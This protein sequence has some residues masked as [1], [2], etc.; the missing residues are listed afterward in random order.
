[1][2][3]NQL[4]LQS[5]PDLPA[6]EKVLRLLG[7]G[8]A[9]QELESQQLEFKQPAE[10][11]KKTLDILADAAVCFA[12]ADGGRI[13][14]GVDD[15]A[16]KRR[17]ALVGVSLDYSLEV[18]RKGI[19]DR[20][21]PPLTLLAGERVEDGAR[22]VVLD[23]PPGVAIH[24]NNAG[25]ATRRLGTECRPF[26]PAEQREF[27]I[28][29]GQVD[30][31]AES[32]GLA[33]E[34][35]SKAELERLRR[36]LRSAGSNELAGLRDRPLLEA[37]RLIAS[38]GLATRAA[39][40]LLGAESDI[41]QIAP[42]YGYSYQYRSTPGTE[43]SHR[44]RGGRS[45]LSAVEMLIDAISA[46]T[47]TRPMNVSGGVQLQLADYPPQAVREFLVN[48]L[49]H[50]SY[51][52]NGSVDV[53]HSPERLTIMSPG[54]LVA[55]VTPA[56]ILT[57]PSTPRHRLLTEASH[58]ASW[59]SAPDRAL[60]GRTGRCFVPGKSLPRF[61]T[62]IFGSPPLSREGVE[63]MLSCAFS[64]LFPKSWGGM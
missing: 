7:R 50:R 33:W 39:V 35:L 62:S 61:M 57:H 48:A 60:T 47:T 31:S 11:V 49:I 21:S 58:G 20:T 30:W 43:A 14:L 54:G 38:D 56:N 29:R 6:I 51:E 53:E 1:M 59:L 25:R 13:V 27:L 12:N 15:K 42:T 55:G 44:F 36:L 26:T 64:G 19:F 28:A 22:L 34:A 2:T 5:P 63:M 3:D 4:S 46:R 37:L 16:T 18:L 9:A 45:L 41:Q 32:S 40:L 24:S 17:E 10:S 8:H 52:T 23:V